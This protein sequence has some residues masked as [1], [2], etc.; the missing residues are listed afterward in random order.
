[1]LKLTKKT[2]YALL[3]LTHLGQAESESITKV[4]EIA[5]AHD[6]PFPVLAKV[7]QQ[8]AKMEFVEPI[9]G[10]QGGY[11]LKTSLREINL[12]QFLE[13]MEKPSGIVDCVADHDCAQMGSCT[14]RTPLQAIDRRIRTVFDGMTL[15]D[16]AVSAGQRES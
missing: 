8:L 2:E 7:M 6:I 1:M 10:A 16:V 14:I 9:Q 12:W 15:D 3:A 5:D 11:R 13:R 4:R